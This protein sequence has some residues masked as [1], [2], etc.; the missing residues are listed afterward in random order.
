MQSLHEGVEGLAS[1]LR[2]FSQSQ[3]SVVRERSSAVQDSLTQ[4]QTNTKQFQV[5]LQST[6]VTVYSTLLPLSVQESLFSTTDHLAVTL[7]PLLTGLS[8]QL[9]L[10]SSLL[11]QSIAGIRTQVSAASLL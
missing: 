10:Q 7:Q 9:A 2:Q 4:S 11:S 3:T 6:L 1:L 8:N 5:T